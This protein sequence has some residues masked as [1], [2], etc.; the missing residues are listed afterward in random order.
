M[1][2]ILVMGVTIALVGAFSRIGL[3]NVRNEISSDMLAQSKEIVIGS[4]LKGGTNPP[5]WLVSP[6]VLNVPSSTEKLY[7]SNTFGVNY[8]GETD[9]GCFDSTRPATTPPYTPLK[10]GIPERR[11]LGRLPWKSLGLSINSP[12]ENDSTGFMPW[13]AFSKNLSGLTPINSELLNNSSDWLKV[14]DMNGALLSDRVAFVIIVPG[15]ALPN[16]SRPPSPNLA[17]PSQYLDTIS[18]PAGCSPTGTSCST[19]YNN[20]DLSETFIT[21]DEHRWMVDPVNPTKQIED[22]TYQFNDKLL[23]VTID[24]LMP[25]IERRLAR[26]VKTCLDDY[27]AWPTNT[28]HRYPWAALVNDTSDYPDRVGTYN[29]YFGRLSDKPNIDKTS[30][31]PPPTGT[32]LSKIQAVQAAL[33][34]Y[35]NNPTSSNLTSLNN[36]GDALKNY[37]SSGTSADIAGNT[38][39]NCSGMP[40]TATLQS[41]LNTAMGMGT[42]DSTMPSS[43]TVIPSCNKLVSSSYWP[44]WRDLIFYQVAEGYQ[45]GGGTFIP[46][47]I[48]GSGNPSIDNNTYQVAVVIA[49]KWLSGQSSRPATNNPANTEYANNFLEINNNHRSKKGSPPAVNF[50]TYKS[51]DIANYSRVNDI[52]LCVDGKTNCQ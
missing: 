49:G 47:H 34:N 2:V 20:A 15:V 19:T 52:V 36:A 42:P 12:S 45:P 14:Y 27:A 48:S 11:C 44:D 1:M 31:N 51:S 35:L 46:L 43:W 30:G 33:D 40:C 41:E 32:L 3:Q 38:A 39:E 24:E 8:D 6:D 23:Y 7:N 17:G 5:G 26:E 37:A 4:L 10:S 25:L 50:E 9:A 18:L 16:Q 13:Y 29:T 22:H 28:N 21:G